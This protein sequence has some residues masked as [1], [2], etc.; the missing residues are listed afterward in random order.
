M[1]DAVTVNDEPSP[2]LI[3][4]TTMKFARIANANRLVNLVFQ[5]KKTPEQRETTKSV[6]SILSPTQRGNRV[7]DMKWSE[8]TE[9]IKMKRE[10]LIA[11]YDS[12]NVFDVLML[13]LLVEPIMEED[14]RHIRKSGC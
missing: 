13:S 11:F 1:S 6:S 8:F 10:V 14:T 5:R 4:R 12:E 3:R 2:G 7:R 9:L